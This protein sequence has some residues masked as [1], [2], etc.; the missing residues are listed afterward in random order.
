[1]YSL[2]DRYF[3]GILKRYV[4]LV[5]IGTLVS[6]IFGLLVLPMFSGNSDNSVPSESKKVYKVPQCR[7]IDLDKHGAKVPPQD[8]S[9]SP[10]EAQNVGA[11][12]P[13]EKDSNLEKMV[14]LKE[15]EAQFM[16]PI[17]TRNPVKILEM[18]KLEE[19]MLKLHQ[20]LG[21]LVIEDSDPLLGIKIGKL[22]LPNLT[23]DNKLP[24]SVGAELVDLLVENGDI[25]GAATV[26]I[27]T[28]HAM[29]SGD[30][31]FTPEHWTERGMSEQGE[32]EDSAVTTDPCCPEEPTLVHLEDGHVHDTPTI[33][34][35]TPQAAK[36]VEAELSGGL[37][38]ERFDKARQLIDEYGTEEGLRRLRES[39]PDAARQ[40]ERHPPISPRKQGENKESAREVP[41]EVESSTQ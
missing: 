18:L 33:Q 25:D 34:P 7:G 9:L 19:E 36:G 12:L 10:R 6:V 5:L 27:A 22:V 2:L 30:E 8:V 24:V 38:L 28:W 21:A 11:P 39:D 31:F 20:E 35:P 4:L 16:K 40:F 41:S 32:G 14:R 26:Y 17:F 23:N 1:M 3:E 29:E 37:S 13:P 15:I